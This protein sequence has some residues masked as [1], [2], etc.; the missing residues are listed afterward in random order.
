VHARTSI[1][2]TPTQKYCTSKQAAALLMVSP[3][4][5]REW[6]RKGL[7]PA[8]CT[9]GGHRRFLMEDLRTFATAHGISTDDGTDSAMN[10]ALRVLLVD[11]DPVFA[12]YLRE[13]IAA[14]CPDARV[15]WA[16]DGFEAGQ[17][18]T[19][20]RPQ[21]VVIDLYMPR[22]DG[23]EL[24]RRLRTSPTAAKANLVILSNSLTDEN[25]T[26]VRA[27]G[28]DRWLGKSSSRDEILRALGI[29]VPPRANEAPAGPPS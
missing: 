11:D 25:I 14:A 6:A 21:L 10:G 26:A 9:A 15:E 12:T 3:V 1:L 24:C 18:T 2:H 16:S 8:V 22:V 17:L 5:V 4:T 27:A 28:A 23:I 29:S 19:T 13:I 20:F 7:L